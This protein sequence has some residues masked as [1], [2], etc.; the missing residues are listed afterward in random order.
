MS[1]HLRK[2]L[3]MKRRVICEIDFIIRIKFKDNIGRPQYI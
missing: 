3:G 2:L 1:S